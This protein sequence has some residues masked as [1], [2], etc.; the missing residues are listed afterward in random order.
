MITTVTLNPCI[1]RTITVEEFLYGG[2]NKVTGIR[3]DVSGKGINAS[4]VLQNLG[5]ETICL[6]FNYIQGTAQ[7]K[8]ALKKLD[9]PCDLVDVDG[10]LRIN[11]KIFDS[12]HRV[13][14]EF[15]ESGHPVTEEDVEKLLGK[16]DEY[17][18]KT[19]ILVLDGS[20]PGGVPASIYRTIIEKANK[21][22]VRTILDASN[23]L[24]A[25]GIKGKP[26][27]IKP[28]IDEFSI[29][30]NRKLK[31]REEIILAARELIR[32]GIRYVCVSMGAEG[33]LM[34][35]EKEACFAP[36]LEL[37]VKGIQ[38]AGDSL[39]AG[40]CIAME[41]GKDMETMLRYAVATAGGSLLRE[42]TQLCEKDD[43]EEL[44][45]Q[46]VIEKL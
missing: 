29:L 40:I 9:I 11:V 23:A 42:G 33:A 5:A 24:L 44:L 25:E 36:A 27:L 21:K 38:G 37:E 39:V 17:L 41:E 31:N 46:V 20:V 10:E 34:V 4:T 16:V 7:V 45:Q 1:D 28:N 26:Y 35:S 8:T 30:M 18:E 14:S 19:T 22:G 2:T 6:G 13:M 3:N 12:A 43:F 32:E 15:N